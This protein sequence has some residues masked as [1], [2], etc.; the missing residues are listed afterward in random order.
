MTGLKFAIARAKKEAQEVIKNSN[1]KSGTPIDVWALAKQFQADVKELNFNDNSVAG[2]LRR[3]KDG[4]CLIAVNS[5][6]S[7]ARQRFTIAHELGHLLLHAV[8]TLHVDKQETATPV[9]FRN[10]ESSKATR[11]NEIEANQ[12]AAELLMPSNEILKVAKKIIDENENIT[13]EE[14]IN[15]LATTYEVS[16][17]AMSIKLGISAY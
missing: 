14:A 7:V 6:N 12:F 9:Y 16:P 2:F 4:T 10:N 15:Q 1:H 11:I 8:E 13:I 5:R 17:A 3:E